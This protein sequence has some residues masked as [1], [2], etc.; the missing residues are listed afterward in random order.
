[1]PQKIFVALNFLFAY[2]KKEF[3]YLA[4]AHQYNLQFLPGHFAKC[5]NHSL[6]P[7]PVK[8]HSSVLK[9]LNLPNIALEYPI[10]MLFGLLMC[11]WDNVFI[12][13]EMC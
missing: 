2:F 6:V 1:M 10:P 11:Y 13:V 7:C 3:H 9:R 8:Y 12:D 4:Q 5:S